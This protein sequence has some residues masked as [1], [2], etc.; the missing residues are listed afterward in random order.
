MAEVYVDTSAMA[1]WKTNMSKINSDCIDSLNDI[2]DSMS[3]FRSAFQGAYA[4]QF[5]DS[6]VDFI[7]KIK[8]SHESMKDLENFIN[9]IVETMEKQ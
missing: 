6:F 9:I 4:D 8:S 7:R 2:S 1:D 5:D 3:E